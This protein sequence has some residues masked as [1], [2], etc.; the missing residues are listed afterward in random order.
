MGLSLWFLLLL[1][2]YRSQVFVQNS[3]FERFDSRPKEQEERRTTNL[4]A[5]LHG[6]EVFDL[7]VT[8]Q[9]DENELIE[10]LTICTYA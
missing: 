7:V 1:S 3:R 5:H 2:Q 6:E 9:I 4:F 8:I 10:M